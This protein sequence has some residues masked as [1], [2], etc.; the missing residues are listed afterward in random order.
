MHRICYCYN[1]QAGSAKVV[2]D[3]KGALAHVFHRR[4]AGISPYLFS[5]YD[6]IQLAPNLLSLLPITIHDSWGKG[7]SSGKS[8]KLEHKL[9]NIADSLATSHKKSG[10]NSTTRKL[11]LPF[12]GFKICLHYDGSIITSGLHKIL[13]MSMHGHCICQY[14]KRKAQWDEATFHRLDWASH[15]RTFRQLTRFR[16]FTMTKLTHKLVHTNRKDRLMYGTDGNC[17]GCKLKEETLQHVLPRHQHLFITKSLAQWLL[18]Q[19]DNIQCWLRSVD[20]ARKTCL[21]HI[22]DKQ[23]LASLFFPSTMNASSSE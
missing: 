23:Q 15:A 20:M 10:P 1:I 12:P 4:Y 21:L 14:I 5:D 6:I 19:G 7:H 18:Q 8:P 16:R 13:C 17:P 22:R 3:N 2:C 11:P 9:N